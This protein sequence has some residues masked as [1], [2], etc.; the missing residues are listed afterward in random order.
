[1]SKTIEADICV[2][3]AGSGGL[4]VAA[5]ASQMGARVVL[6]EKGKM[7]GDCL[8]YGCVPSKALIA[9]AAA[10]DKVRHAGRFGVNGHEP[11][12]DFPAV[13]DHLRSVI[14]AIA[15]HDSVERFEGLGVTV[16]QAA[17]R[18]TGARELQAGEARVKAKRFVVATG[19]TA[20]V[21]PIPG[22]EGVHYL[23]NE[24]VFE[25]AER[26]EHLIVIGGGPIGAELAQA[27]RRLGARV[28]L[29]EMDRV[30][31]KDDPEITAVARR[32]L[33]EDGVEIHEGVAVKEVMPEG[34]GIAVV[35]QKDGAETRLAG[36]HLLV[37]AGRKANVD[38]L[39]LEAAGV[40]YTSRGIEVDRRLRS[41]NKRIFAVG[42][43]ALVEGLG[44]YQF[45]HVAG[46]HAGIVIR[47]ALFRL[48]A[49]V[50]YKALPRV[51]YTDPEI[52]HVGLTEAEAREIHGGKVRVLTS[53]F[54]ENDRARAE[55]ATEG[56]V[57]VVVGARGRI[58]GASIVGLHAGELLQPWVLAIDGGLKIGALAGMIAPYP[59]L[60]EANKRAAGS[61]YTPSLFG[62]RTK[63]IVRFL[64]RFG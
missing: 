11:A 24:T 2:I 21:P 7:G 50:D 4:S 25:L 61:Y 10:A 51:I 60:G 39:G 45:T 8:N 38:G 48:P 31:A 40:A 30:L 27:Q 29:L 28:S 42:D 43:V 23:T 12:V 52:A 59:T 15:P 56:L 58:L 46:Y 57:K 62:E 55:R 32:R 63:K 22:L 9:A 18:F 16:I 44:V 17:A 64:L 3:G 54:A 20:A 41:S 47:N 53:P 6:V 33:E 36:S 35:L 13:R 37:A 1:M 34:N 19:S 14:A 49:K 26:P 5:G